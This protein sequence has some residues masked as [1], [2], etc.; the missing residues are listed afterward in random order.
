MASDLVFS[1]CSLITTE[2][3]NTLKMKWLEN[4]QIHVVVFL[5]IIM[6]VIISDRYRPSS[7]GCC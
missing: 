2:N 1:L 7:W 6:Q 5:S 4:Y 3:C